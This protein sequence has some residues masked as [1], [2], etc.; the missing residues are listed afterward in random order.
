[1]LFH[2]VWW[3][4]DLRFYRSTS[5]QPDLTLKEDVSQ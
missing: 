1:M 2:L 3:P 5:S 4:F